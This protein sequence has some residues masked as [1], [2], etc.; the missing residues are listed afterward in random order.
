VLL[1][2]AE[3]RADVITVDVLEEGFSYA[4]QQVRGQS[5]L[6]PEDFILLDLVL[7]KGILSDAN[8]TLEDLQ[9]LKVNEFSEILPIL[10]KLMQQDLLRRL[11][12]DSAAEY[13]PTP[14]LLPPQDEA[15]D[16]DE[17]DESPQ[18]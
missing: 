4:N 1:K 13:A 14:L 11:P 3:L 10:D 12:C 17:D 18:N 16:N 6:T 5:G 2:A 7:E 15:D 8:V 9:R